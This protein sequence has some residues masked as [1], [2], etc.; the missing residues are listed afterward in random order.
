MLVSLSEGC[1]SG[2]QPGAAS[3]RD[4]PEVRDAAAY[5]RNTIGVIL[6]NVESVAVLKISSAQNSV[7]CE[8]NCEINL[9]DSISLDFS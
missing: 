3:I 7:F 8:V 9:N 2:A 5:I 4:G 1:V 6:I